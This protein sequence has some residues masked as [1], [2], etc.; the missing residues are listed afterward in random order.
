MNCPNCHKEASPNEKFCTACGTKLDTQVGEGNPS[1]ENHSDHT[2][3]QAQR[4]SQQASQSD[5]FSNQATT[6]GKGFAQICLAVLKYPTSISQAGASGF[7]HGLAALLLFSVFMP[8]AIYAFIQ[9]MPFFSAFGGVSFGDIVPE[10]FLMTIITQAVVVGSIFVSLKIGKVQV[11]FKE[12]VAR[13][14]GLM[15]IP[16]ALSLLLILIGFVNVTTLFWW[17][18][19]LIGITSNLALITAIYS[20]ASK[21][22]QAGVDLFYLPVIAQFILYLVIYFYVE[23]RLNTFMNG[24]FEMFGA[25]NMF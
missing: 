16:T 18:I 20:Y 12:V 24:L 13:Y 23:G 3:V 15:I 22:A 5:T 9:N 4:P 1:S 2:N 8:L 25:M 10:V 17:T 21:K 19:I 7:G 6:F 14:G 11:A